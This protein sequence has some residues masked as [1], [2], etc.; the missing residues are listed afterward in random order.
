MSPDI[1][2][3]EQWRVTHRNRGILTEKQRRYLLGEVELGERKEIRM[4]HQM[5]ARLTHGL[6]D[7][8]LLEETMGAIDYS[9]Q[10]QTKMFPNERVPIALMALAFGFLS[11]LEDS[12]A[13]K[14]RECLQEAAE[15]NCPIGPQSG[16]STRSAVEREVEFSVDVSEKDIDLI[17][18]L[19]PD[20][21]AEKF[22]DEEL[23]EILTES[24]KHI[25]CENAKLATSF[26]DGKD[27]DE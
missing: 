5:G 22:S 17:E 7:L 11:Q 25:F 27:T 6:L 16:E 26:P 12:N 18:E 3:P 14:L 2:G 1:L 10:M 8:I 19:A 21:L 15:S 13:D 20:E 23:E 4:K 24:V 9:D